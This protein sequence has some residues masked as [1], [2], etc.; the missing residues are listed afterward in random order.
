MIVMVTS[1]NRGHL[2]WFRVGLPT[3]CVTL[4][5]LLNHFMHEFSQLKMKVIKVPN[6]PQIAYDNKHLFLVLG[7]C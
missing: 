6:D 7:T 2:Q 3:Y 1:T 4:D 5:K